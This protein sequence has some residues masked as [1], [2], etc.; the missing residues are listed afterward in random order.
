MEWLRVLLEMLCDIGDVFAEMNHAFY[1]D[2]AV[3]KQLDYIGAI[4]GAS[5]KMK[6]ISAYIPDGSLQD[7]DYKA[8][9][10]ARI[11]Q[12]MWNGENE[13]LPGLWSSVYPDIKMTYVD[14]QDMTMDVN[15]IGQVSEVLLELIMRGYIVPVPMGVG[16][17][18]TATDES[19]DAGRYIAIG[20][21]SY[22]AVS[23][24][25]DLRHLTIESPYA[26]YGGADYAI[27]EE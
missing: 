7:P 19:Q 22:A 15:I 9:I 18:L 26:D 16:M 10:M 27:L 2:D 1:L 8:F 23:C 3:G 21:S 25:V 5:R 13:T 4:V 14:N 17:K 20:S 24:M 12:N 11:A 6:Y